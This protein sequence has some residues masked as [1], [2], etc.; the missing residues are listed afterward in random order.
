M[1]TFKVFSSIFFLVLFSLIS[2]GVWGQVVISQ[3]YE[4]ASNNKWIEITNI[5]NSDFDLTASGLKIGQWNISGS[6]GNGIISGLPTS[7]ITLNGVL[8][9]GGMYLLRNSSASTSIPHSTMPTAQNS[10]TTVCGFNGNDA[11]ALFTG[12][13]TLT[14]VDV[15]GVGINNVD[16]SYHR[17]SN[18]SNPTPTFDANE[19]TLISLSDCALSSLQHS[20][21]IGTHVSNNNCTWLG[22]T[23]SDPTNPINWNTFSI[24]LSTNNVVF[25][26][27]LNSVSYPLNSIIAYSTLTLNSGST[28]LL[29][30]GSELT[31]TGT[32]T[33]NGTMTIESG[34]TLVQTT[35]S[36]TIAGSGIYQVKQ[37]LNASGRFWYL[38]VPLGSGAYTEQNFLD[39]LGAGDVLRKRNEASSAWE[40]ISGTGNNTTISAGKGFNLYIN[41]TTPTLTFQ[42]TGSTYAFNNGSITVPLTSSGSSYTGYNLVCNP[43]PSYVDWSLVTKSGLVDE[44]IWY[45]IYAGG[46][47]TFGTINAQGV[48]TSVGG[49]V[50]TKYLPPMQA[51]WVKAASGGGSLTFDNEDRTHFVSIGSSVAGLKNTGSNNVFIRMNIFQGEKTDQLIVYT[52]PQA[53]L[54]LDAYDSDKMMQLTLPQIYTKVGNQK[55]VIN[56]LHPSKKRQSIPVIME[57]PSTGI[58]HFEFEELEIG[59]GII[60]LEDK[61]EEIMQVLEPGTVYEFYANSGINAERFVLHFQL[62]DD[63]TPVNVFNEVNSAANFSGKGASVH[64]EAAGVVIIKLPATTEGVTNIQIR[65]AAG[66]LVYTG[67]TNTLETSVQLEQANG[68]YYV[69]L[70]SAAGVEV[71]KVFIQQ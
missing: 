32:L 25:N 23:N 3:V 28:F 38:G 16:V 45:R 51:F 8:S 41:N 5:G 33:N 4:G 24:P 27:A 36:S 14:L 39:L 46:A 55:T 67:S 66:K 61:Q 20:C 9:P 68:I 49:V 60:W 26:S 2:G 44:T 64:A 15:F 29:Q 6:T 7:F 17:K 13:S 63:A 65:D 18:V 21:Y 19:W 52:D 22:A 40:I 53:S 34:A 11:L 62:L 57:L 56:A 35:N 47:M 58:H 54:E 69:T 30:S 50:V 42:G 71:R 48:S 37:T 1:K 10:N 59:N 70:N 12:T 31:L 43:Y